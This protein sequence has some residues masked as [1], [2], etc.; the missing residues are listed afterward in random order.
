MHLLLL[1]HAKSSWKDASADDHDRSLNRRGREAASAM[2]RYLADQDLVPDLALVSS[3]KRTQETWA[4]LVAEWPAAPA[5]KTLRALYLAAPTQILAQIRRAPATATRLLVLGHNPGLEVLSR[6]L[7]GAGSD[8]EALRQLQ[9]KYPTGAL[10]AFVCAVDGWTHLT[11]DA[12]R[13][14]RFVT[15]RW[16][17]GEEDD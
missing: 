7:A 17:T 12:T 11:K 10:A 2:G 8:P 6:M 9:E 15:P 1:R 16:L 13:L 14:E 4:R 5:E 3:S